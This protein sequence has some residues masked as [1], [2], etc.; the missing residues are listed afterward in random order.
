MTYSDFNIGYFQI[1]LYSLILLIYYIIN[2]FIR[3]SIIK[4]IFLINLI[5]SNFFLNN[6]LISKLHA[7][8][9]YKNF[10]ERLAK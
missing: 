7:A 5:T 4:K 3:F 1:T 8:D 2:K 9:I 6:I 10:S